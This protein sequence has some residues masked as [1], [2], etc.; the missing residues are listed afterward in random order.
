MYNIIGV[1][2]LDIDVM[3][4][5]NWD[6]VINE[7]EV[8]NNVKNSIGILFDEMNIVNYLWIGDV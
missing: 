6:I 7:I 5:F 3:F 1:D 8:I 4:L 2:Y